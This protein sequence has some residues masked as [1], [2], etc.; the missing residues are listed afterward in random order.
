MKSFLC[1]LVLSL[2]STLPAAAQDEAGPQAFF[3]TLMNNLEKNDA[4]AFIGAGDAEFQKAMT[5]ELVKKASDQLSPKMKK[6]Y[7]VAYLG[8]VR[9]KGYEVHLWNLSFKDDDV[10]LL[11]SVSI[12]DGKVIG[13]VIK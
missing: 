12:R 2:M 11:T 10:E 9:K 3:L 1:L 6:G 5:P 4:A 8:V 13:F 7:G